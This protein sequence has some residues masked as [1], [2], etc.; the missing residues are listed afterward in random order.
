MTT[1]GRLGDIETVS[2]WDRKRSVV[3]TVSLTGV[4]EEGDPILMGRGV[5]VMAIGS[6]SGSK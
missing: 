3:V 1:S 2:S 5:F 4:A 6:K